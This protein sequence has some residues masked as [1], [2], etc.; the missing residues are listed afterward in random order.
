[1]NQ[2]W[3][4]FPPTT[5]LDRTLEKYAHLPAELSSTQSYAKVY[6]GCWEMLQNPYAN[7]YF[8]CE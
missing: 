6:S 8:D 5:Q 2:L 3:L 7:T 4:Q 1:V